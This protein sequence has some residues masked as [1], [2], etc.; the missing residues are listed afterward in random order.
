M[1][2]PELED[3]VDRMQQIILLGRQKRNQV[4][5]KVKTPLSKLTVLHKDKNV[6]DEISKL[7]SYIQTELNIKEVE[8]SQDEDSFIKLFCKPNSP[9]LGKRFGKEFGKVR[10]QIEALGVAELSELEQKGELTLDG[11][12]FKSEDILVFR[13]AKEGTQALSNRYISIDLD[14]ELNPELIHE[15]LAR[16]VVNRIQKT[17]KDL[18]FNVDDRINVGFETDPELAEAILKHSDYI[19]SETLSVK[20]EKGLRGDSVDF[21]VESYNLKLSIERV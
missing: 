12:V 17:R 9:V 19:M 11:E 20:L 8:Y 1:I 4:Q 5:I 15:G 16:E 6:L 18:G 2:I 3:A 10:K 21:K 14:C 13:E 7:E